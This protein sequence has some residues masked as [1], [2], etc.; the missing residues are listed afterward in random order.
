M[1][2]NI[3]PHMTGDAGYAKARAKKAL[4][5]HQSRTLRILENEVKLIRAAQPG[6]DRRKLEEEL[7][8][9]DIENN[10]WDETMLILRRV[11]RRT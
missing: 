3:L 4:N 1:S 7:R 5:R 9:R 8:E 10:A 2:K 11:F 6:Q